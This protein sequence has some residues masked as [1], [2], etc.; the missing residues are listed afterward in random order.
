[1][2]GKNAGKTPKVRKPPQIQ[3]KTTHYFVHWPDA[4]TEVP[5]QPNSV[6]VVLADAVATIAVRGHGVRHACAGC[7]EPATADDSP[8]RVQRVENICMVVCRACRRNDGGERAAP[9]TH[10]TREF[11][12]AP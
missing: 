3:R 1:M 11:M 8:G 7:A 4:A 5:S 12:G 2:S 6:P 9:A 10:P